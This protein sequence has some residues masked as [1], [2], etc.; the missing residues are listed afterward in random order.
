MPVDLSELGRR[1]KAARTNCD[2]SQDAVAK[3][4]GLPRAAIIQIEAGERPVT[5]EQLDT[6][7]R[8]YRRPAAEFVMEQAEDLLVALLRASPEIQ[9]REQVEAEIMRHVAICRAGTNLERIL[10]LP[11]RTGPPAYDVPAP[12]A[13]VDAI[14]QGNYVARQERLRLGLG[15]NPIADMADIISA[16]G[17]WASGSKF[18]DEM[19][20]VFLRSQSIGLVVLVNYHHPRVRKR[21][22]YAHE[23]AHA[24]LDRDH[25]ATISTQRNRAEL[26]EVRANAFAAAFLLPAAGVRRFLSSR[27]KGLQSRLETVVYDPSIEKTDEPVRATKRTAP[28]SQKISYQDVAGL[29]HLYGA[30]YQ[31]GAYRLKGLG[32]VNERELKELLEK[33]EVGLEYLKMLD[34]YDDLEA[35]DKSPKRADRELISQ[36]VDLAIEAFRRDQIT[37]ERL[38]ELGPT[39]GV[40][41]RM[42]AKLAEAAR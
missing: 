25:T 4:L 10:D 18:P 24:L 15:D 12:S 3:E 21:F 17:I 19:S 32:F 2:M 26:V 11:F 14:E 13:T 40:P 38:L 8:L 6:F 36:V 41:G 42:L 23:Y 27:R 35:V 7:A 22:S 39:L 16:T 28:G 33:Q 29:A 37:A 31:A 34:F 1:L 30:S 20:G 9:D 5:L